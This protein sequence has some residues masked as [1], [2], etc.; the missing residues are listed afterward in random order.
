MKNSYGDFFFLQINIYCEQQTMK[1]AKKKSC[2]GPSLEA[3]L[4]INLTNNNTSQTQRR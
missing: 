1:P 3:I 2:S 4:R